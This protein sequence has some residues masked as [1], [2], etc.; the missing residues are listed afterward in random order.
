MLKEVLRL[1]KEGISDLVMEIA[2]GGTSAGCSLSLKWFVSPIEAAGSTK[3]HLDGLGDRK[4]APGRNEG[5][6]ARRR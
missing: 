3:Y 5:S 1:T 4:P 2:C 6:R